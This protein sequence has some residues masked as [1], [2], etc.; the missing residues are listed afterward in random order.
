MPLIVQETKSYIVQKF[1]VYDAYISGR[2][3]ITIIG[4]SFAIEVAFKK[5]ASLIKCIT[6]VDGTTINDPGDLDLVMSKYI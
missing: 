1:K 2:S 3:D 4:S 5:C 6:K